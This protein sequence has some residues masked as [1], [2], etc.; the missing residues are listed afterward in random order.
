L[1]KGA[2]LLLGPVDFFQIL[3]IEMVIGYFTNLFVDVLYLFF[4]F[5][6]S[7]ALSE[8]E[9]FLVFHDVVED[10]INYISLNVF[11]LFDGSLHLSESFGYGVFSYFWSTLCNYPP[12]TI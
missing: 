10:F 7:C 11:L 5:L 2:D 8:D 1:F 9:I 3:L 12:Y 6:I 4:L